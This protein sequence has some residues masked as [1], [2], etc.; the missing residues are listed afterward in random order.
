MTHLY[1]FGLNREL[2]TRVTL[3]E[4]HFGEYNLGREARTRVAL[5]MDSLVNTTL[6][7]RLE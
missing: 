3:E 7:K 1:E 6:A 5:G 4:N 2:K